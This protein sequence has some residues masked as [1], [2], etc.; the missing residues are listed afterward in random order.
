MKSKIPLLSRDKDPL[1]C[2]EIIPIGAEPGCDFTFRV[3]E[4]PA[5]THIA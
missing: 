4:F 5:E 3:L 1:G 2:S